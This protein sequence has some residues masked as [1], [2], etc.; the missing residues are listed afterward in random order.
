MQVYENQLQNCKV[1]AKAANDNNN[2][3]KEITA[4]T[5]DSK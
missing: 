2:N 5:S 4:L 1:S 3:N